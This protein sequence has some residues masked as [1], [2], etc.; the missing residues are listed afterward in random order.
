MTELKLKV[1]KVA[2]YNPLSK[3][4]GFAT[5]VI[6]NGTAVYTDIATEATRRT[7]MHH[8]EA[9][10]AATLLVEA[11]A[12]K[13]KQGYI[14]DMGPVGKLYPSC[15]SKWTAT[16]EEQ[17]LAAVKPYVNYHPSNEIDVAIKTA[18]IGWVKE[19]TEDEETTNQ[20][21]DG[22][23]NTGGNTDSGSDFNEEGGLG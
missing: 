2:S 10:L 3:Q 13:L 11:V 1:K 5:R 20:T 17:T 23:D 12:D 8:G 14:V 18:S 7:T 15:A 6:T 19:E 16:A 9:Q 22:G 4:K 21:T